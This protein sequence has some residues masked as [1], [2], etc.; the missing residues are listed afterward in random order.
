MRLAVSGEIHDRKGKTGKTWK[1][2]ILAGLEYL[3]NLK[4]RLSWHKK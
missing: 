4:R 1:E 2:I 3:E